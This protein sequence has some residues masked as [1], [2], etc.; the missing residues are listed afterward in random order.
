MCFQVVDC[1]S[2]PYRNLEGL[3]IT[4]QQMPFIR[5]IESLDQEPHVYFTITKKSKSSIIT[6]QCMLPTRS[7]DLISIVNPKILSKIQ[8][9]NICHHECEKYA[10]MQRSCFRNAVR[11]L[12]DALGTSYVKGFRLS[13]VRRKFS[14]TNYDCSNLFS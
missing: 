12:Q 14:N 4:Q 8:T 9:Q 6:I 11:F 5:G 1:K 10:D 2:H 3:F 7:F 13:K